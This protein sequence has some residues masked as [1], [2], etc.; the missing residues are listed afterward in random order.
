MAT[1]QEPVNVIVESGDVVANAGISIVPS[2]NGRKTV[3]TGGIDEALSTATIAKYIMI[4]A[5]TD[6]TGLIC[7]GI[8]GVDCALSTRTGIPL[9]AGDTIGVPTDDLST[10]FI[11]ST[12]N[13]DGVSFL[14]WN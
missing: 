1:I 8:T 11:D 2:G 6:N 4:T 12:V 3:T 13:G 10:V 7:V 9:D 5:E 14:Y